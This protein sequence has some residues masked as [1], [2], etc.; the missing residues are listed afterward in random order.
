M[1]N[2]KS[3]LL[4]ILI[5]IF[6]FFESLN[7]NYFLLNTIAALYS[8]YLLLTL[9]KKELYFAG[10]FTGI[11]WF[12]WVGYSFIYY[13]LS[14]MIPIV[15]ILIGAVY[16]L[17]FYFGG[18]FSNPFL[19]AGYFYI[20]SFIDILGFNW[21]KLEL[22]FV[23]SYLG[24][25]KVEFFFIVLATALLVYFIEKNRF[26]L[27]IWIYSTLIVILALINITSNKNIE[28][29]KLDIEM[30]TTDVAQNEK[31]DFAIRDRYILKYISMIDKAIENNKDLIVFPETAFPVVLNDN[32]RVED[33]LL[34]RSK[35]IS[36]ITGALYIKDGLFYNSTYLFENGSV[37]VAH[38]VVLV[39]FGEAVPLPEKLRD[40]IND[41]FYNG[42]KDY[43]TAEMPTTF[44]IKGEKFRSAI[45]YEATTDEI[46]ENLD[47]KYAIAISNNAWFVPSTQPDLQRVL[48]R[49]YA[50][51]YNILIYSITNKSKSGIIRP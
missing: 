5:S 22:P 9:Y 21:F 17:L 50:K 24:I 2:L 27:S 44:N 33:M 16:G 3:L 34:E 20:V 7:C 6:I 46:Y 36:I 15:I 4:A 41:S 31:W 8:I 11:I 40:W 51:K 10:F 23:N 29:S 28:N 35:S 14:Y 47:T 49:Y 38:K 12:W 48:L 45:C 25:S 13:E 42:A 39:P 43:E 18:F 30:V 37:E 19:R 26:K 32:K 1:F